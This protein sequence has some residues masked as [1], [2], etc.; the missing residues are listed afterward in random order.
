VI[1]HALDDA[2]HLGIRHV[3]PDREREALL[4]AWLRDRALS[5]PNAEPLLIPGEEMER[6]E[7]DA[8]ADSVLLQRE[9]P[10]GPPRLSAARRNRDLIEVHAWAHPLRTDGTPTTPRSPAD[11]ARDRLAPG[12][13]GIRAAHLRQGERGLDVG[14]VVLVPELR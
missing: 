2:V 11:S 3:R 1:P 13:H 6:L 4:V 12:A 14:H 10:G 7:V 8:R 9:R 5:G